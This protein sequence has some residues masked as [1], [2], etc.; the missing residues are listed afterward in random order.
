MKFMLFVAPSIPATPE[1]REHLRP[2]ARK[3]ACYQEM[4]EQ[5]RGLASLAEE[6]G[7]DAFGITEHHFHSE[8]FEISTSPMLL[9]TDL[10]ARTRRI[11]FLTLGLVA[12]AWDPIRLAEETAVFDQLS[13]GR[14]LAGFARGYQSRWSNVLGQQFHVTNAPS[15]GSAID[16]R[17]REVYEEVVQLVRKAWT[18]E[19]IQFKGNY[20]EVPFPHDAGIRGWP[21]VETT[22]RYGAPG[23]IDEQGVI[24]RVCVVP[25]PFQEPHP[26]MFQPFSIS[27]STIR[28]TAEQ[29]IVPYILTSY[30]PDFQRSCRIYQEVAAKSGRDLH[31]GESVGAIRT[32][33][34]GR[35]DAEAVE[36][37]RRTQVE[38]TWNQWL[39]P[40]GFWEAFRMPDDNA[41]FPREPF[42]PLP[43]SEW[44]AERMLKSR[45]AYAGTPDKVAQEIEDLRSI[46]GAGGSLDWFGWFFD[47]GLMPFDEQVQQLRTFAETVMSRCR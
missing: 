5:V 10:A 26:P 46:H 30:P 35:T 43:R 32:V 21:A 19:S 8:G 12:P 34:F 37:L 6:L 40:F 15:D 29:N 25:R 2:I 41:R 4:L 24:R 7:F 38:Q 20:Y 28:Y 31:L 45:Y 42:T 47:Q 27:E 9:L 39:G 16:R 36:L 1:K 13:G 18:E 17:N 11:K 3:T 33:H 22:R 23:E 14:Y 44:T